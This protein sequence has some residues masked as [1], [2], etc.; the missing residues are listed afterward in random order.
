VSGLAVGIHPFQS[1]ISP[2]IGPSIK[3]KPR[4]NNDD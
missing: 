3:L 1:C 4:V 2:W